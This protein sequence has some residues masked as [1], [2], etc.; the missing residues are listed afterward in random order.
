MPTLYLIRGLPG[1]GKS[2]IG[3]AICGDE[4]FAADDWFDLKA[5]NEGKTYEEV[6]NPTDLP[7]AHQ[8]CQDCVVATMSTGVDLAV[9]NTFSQRWEA[10]PYFKLVVAFGYYVQIIECQ[11]SFVNIHGVPE[12]AIQAMRDRWEPLTKFHDAPVF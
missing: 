1:S 5:K 10:E 3:R 12:E 6:F 8:Y 2:T 11:S 7:E 9:C 4:S